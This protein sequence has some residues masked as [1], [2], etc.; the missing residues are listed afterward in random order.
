VDEVGRGALA[1]PVVAAAVILP[2]RFA[3]RGVRDSKLVAEHVRE[4]LHDLIRSEAAAVGIGIVD[5][6]TIDRINI[7]NATLRAMKAAIV[8]C[9]NV[10]YAIIDGLDPVD[11]E[12]QQE[13]VVSGDRLVLSIAA[14]SIVAKV[15]RDRM[16]RSWDAEYP[17]YGFAANKG[18]GTAQHRRAILDHGPSPIHRISFLGKLSQQR[19]SL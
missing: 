13:S 9:G 8:D 3:V 2:D 6:G 10:D 4:S 15:T 14:A 7:R 18:Y 1:G 17:A 19:L 16:L 12:L 11:A 5:N